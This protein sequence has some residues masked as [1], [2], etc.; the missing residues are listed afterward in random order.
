MSAKII[1]KKLKSKLHWRRAADEHGC[2]GLWL[3]GQSWEPS[4]L[5]LARQV[6]GYYRFEMA[7]ETGIPL[8]DLRG[9]E[10]RDYSMP[11]P[12]IDHALKIALF[13]NWPVEF[14]FGDEV[15]LGRADGA[16]F[17]S[18]SRFLDMEIER[19]LLGGAP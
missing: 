19:V 11:P 7:R 15:D 9:Y 14:F 12:T 3:N 1:A 17:V 16:S 6:R 2:V 4:R 10:R 5:I 8:K 13:L 18:G